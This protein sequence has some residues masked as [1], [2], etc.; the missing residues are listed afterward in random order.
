[1]ANERPEL[2]LVEPLPPGW[3]DWVETWVL[4]YVRDEALWPVL[5]ALLGHVVVIFAPLVLYV[6][7]T[8]SPTALGALSLLVLASVGLVG[9]ETV[10]FRRPGGVTLVVL[11]TW[12]VS[13]GL[14][15]LA[16]RTGTF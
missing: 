14:A 10:R 4:P 5:V 9:F 13:L 3:P 11:A 16:D 8:R 15:W 6:V 2:R 12:A 1:M 7:R